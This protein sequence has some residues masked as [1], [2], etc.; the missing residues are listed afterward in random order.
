MSEPAGNPLPMSIIEEIEQDDGWIFTVVLDLDLDHS[1]TLMLRLAWVDYNF[2]SPSG[3]AI[4]GD[5]AKAVLGM[6]LEGIPANELPS[7][8]DAARVRRLIP[9]ADA[10]LPMLIR[11]NSS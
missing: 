9:D 3:S 11:R 7:R 6:F 5:V 10:R 4:P 8:L 1:R 2:W